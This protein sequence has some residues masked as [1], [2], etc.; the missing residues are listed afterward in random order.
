[1]AA[2]KQ[3]LEDGNSSP[4]ERPEMDEPRATDGYEDER[5]LPRTQLDI[6]TIWNMNSGE[7]FGIERAI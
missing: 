7:D 1:M 2:N 6:Q 5:H 3:V 4:F